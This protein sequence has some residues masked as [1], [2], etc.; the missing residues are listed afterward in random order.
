MKVLMVCLGNICRSPMA[1]GILR[2]RAV[3]LNKHFEID[4]AGTG[5]YHIGENPDSRAVAC[6]KKHGHDISTL[7]ARQFKSSDF[8]EFDQIFAMDQSNFDNIVLLARNDH[9]IAKVKLI[10]EEIEGI[11]N[12]EVPDPYFGGD[13]GFEHVY[14]LL[15]AAFDRFL[16]RI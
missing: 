6:M 11:P 15:D 1:E 16:N 3:A 5:N 12:N 8:D 13:E 4:S 9:D 2:S 14:N 10:L 7:R